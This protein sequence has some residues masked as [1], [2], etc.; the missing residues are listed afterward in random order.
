M[1]AVGEMAA[2]NGGRG[3]YLIR[4]RSPNRQTRR[5]SAR[6]EVSLVLSLVDQSSLIVPTPIDQTEN[7]AGGDNLGPHYL[8]TTWDF[9]G[10]I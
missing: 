7:Q 4:P 1:V 9:A 5:E 3:L 6:S 2:E 8:L 10:Y